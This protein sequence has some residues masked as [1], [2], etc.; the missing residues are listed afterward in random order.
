MPE[1]G[2]AEGER[3]GSSPGHV[4][5]LGHGILPATPPD[6]ARVLVDAVRELSTRSAS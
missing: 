6:H 2:A 1:E 4:F 5:N 3:P